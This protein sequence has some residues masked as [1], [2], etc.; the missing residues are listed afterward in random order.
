VVGTLEFR[1]I[2]EP[3][4][5]VK[6]IGGY[7][8]A[9]ARRID[10]EKRELICEDIFKINEEFKL[11]FD[12][13][14]VAC[15]SKTNTFGTPG[16]QEREGK[17]VF[18]LK[19]LYHARQVRN[20]ILECFEQAAIHQTNPAE[21]DRLLSFV[22]VGG[23]PTSCELVGEL[24]DF[25]HQDVIRFYPDLVPHISIHLVEASPKLLGSFDASIATF[26]KRKFQSKQIKV[27]TGV[28]VKSYDHI[29][30]KAYLSDDTSLDVGM[31]VW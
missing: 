4:R 2:Q 28:A 14:V 22:V 25:I 31:L 13:L 20:R 26:V 5:T 10:Y 16:I 3:V 11:E 23:G 8:Q 17:E 15:G 19:H 30:G 9:K 24:H 12:Y 1:A 29:T 6:N 18:F 27:K 7:Y 21:R